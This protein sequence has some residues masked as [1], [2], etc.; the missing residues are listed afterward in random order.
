LETFEIVFE[1]LHVTWEMNL[2]WFFGWESMLDRSTNADDPDEKPEMDWQLRERFGFT[3]FGSDAAAV[4]RRVLRRGHIKTTEKRE[5]VRN[6][7]A[8][9]SNMETLGIETYDQLAL[10][11]DV[12]EAEGTTP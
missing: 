7:I 9:Q 12:K 5:V 2:A 6:L 3:R 1:R 8:N 4:T 10:H 11:L